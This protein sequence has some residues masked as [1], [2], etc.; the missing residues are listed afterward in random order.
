MSEQVLRHVLDGGEIGRSMFGPNPALVIA[1]DHV[2][3]PVQAVLDGPMAAHDRSE[4]VRQHD[5]RGDIKACFLRGFSINL[6]AAFDHDDAV[7]AGPGVACLQPSDIMDDGGGSGLD[8]A[9]IAIDR[10][11]LADRGVGKAP[12]LLF[13][14][15]D[16]D[17]L[18]Q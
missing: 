5:Q 2:H 18:P 6:A 13:R 9:M 16:F 10:R 1:E 11:V 12:G 7:Q 17:I 8:A 15:K 14:G 3:D 4:E